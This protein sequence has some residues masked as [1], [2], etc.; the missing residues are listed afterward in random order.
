MKHWIV[1]IVSFLSVKSYSQYYLNDIV[2]NNQSNQHY[3]LLKQNKVRKV[4][5]FNYG[6]NNELIEGFNVE[7]EL[8][9]D[10]RSMT[11]TTNLPN[12]PGSVITNYFANNKI[13][14]TTEVSNNLE[15][16]TTYLYNEKGLIK[17][18]TSITIDTS[19]N[20]TSTETHL[21]NYNEQQQPVVMLKVKNR[22]DTTRIEFILDEH[23]N[24]VE[25]HW[26]KKG[27][28]LETY[29]YYYDAK[30][31]LTDVVRFNAK[32]KKLLPDYLYDYN[33]KG[34]IITMKQLSSG[35]N[36]YLVWKYEYKENGLK[37]RETCYDNA[38]NLMGR[39]EYGYQ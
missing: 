19:V 37:E 30:N 21:W 12:R 2:A 24:A 22:T 8:S 16:T 38:N 36:H 27:A 25:E 9:A 20:Y 31:E 17:S 5:A 29:Y 23:G 7:Q 6:A 10:S 26:R 34:Q 4:K 33:A 11:L 15:T 28:V 13:S 1:V 35:G 3:I 14:K 39:V 18:I 32:Y